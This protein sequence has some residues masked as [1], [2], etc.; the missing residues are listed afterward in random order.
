MLVLYVLLFIEASQDTAR[1]ACTDKTAHCAAAAAAT[2][3]AAA[4]AVLSVKG[5]LSLSLDAASGTDGDGCMARRA[6]RLGSMLSNVD[7]CLIG[8]ARYIVAY[9]RLLID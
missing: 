1:C 2:T 3:T 6:V 7:S 4:A 9:Y 5:A 8:F